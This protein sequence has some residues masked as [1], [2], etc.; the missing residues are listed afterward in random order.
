MAANKITLTKNDESVLFTFADSDHYLT[1]NGTIEVPL[2][3]LSLVIDESDMVTFRK[4]ASN[5]IFV[6]AP[7]SN[8]GMKKAELEEWYA[9]NMVDGGIN[10]EDVQELIDESID[11][12]IVSV[13]YDSKNHVLIF[14][15][16]NGNDITIDATDFIKDGMVSNV[17]VVGTNLVI[18]FNTD[19][20]KNPIS[21]PL[22]SF[23]DGSQY[24]DKTEIDTKLAT[25]AD[26]SAVTAAIDAV[27]TSLSGKADVS[28]VT[29]IAD[30]LSGKQDT[31]VSGT[32]IKTVNNETLLG[33]GNL[34]LATTSAV[35]QAQYDA[36]EQG[37]TL[38]P[39]MLYIITDASAI[40]IDNY[41]TS[42]Q[43]VSAIT[44]AV[45]GKADSTLVNAIAGQV[46]TKVNLSTYNTYTAATATALSGKVDN[47]DAVIDITTA[48]SANGTV[49]QYT[50][51]GTNRSD[52][53]LIG[54]INGEKIAKLKD[55]Q[56][57]ETSAFTAYSA[58]T[59]TSLSGKANISDLEDTELTL[60]QAINVVD[61]KVATKADT[62]AVTAIS[63]SLSGKQDTLIA[64]SGITIS[65]NVISADG[66]GSVIV[67]PTF[68]VSST[69]PVANSAITRNLTNGDG[70]VSYGGGKYQWE[71][72]SVGGYG[73]NK[74]FYLDTINGEPV[75]RKYSNTRS[76]QL[77]ETSAITTSMTSG[78]TDSQVPSAKAVY[79][80]L[81]AK[82]D[83]LVSGTNIK[84]INN[85]ARTDKHVTL[86]YYKNCLSR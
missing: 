13:S 66:G 50:K 60:A 54:S 1:G 83:A 55:F 80:T 38:D 73:T 35:T 16:R 86:L 23:F 2:N 24:Y 59:E 62:S 21:I 63:D 18:T 4:A 72:Y 65:G 64:G 3:S 25:K 26:V 51:D 40:D 8:F 53:L 37:G 43:T 76:L 68:D 47:G 45:S 7:I 57:L 82:Q 84:T 12:T 29:T 58:A 79:D 11:K 22:T 30:S 49:L 5:D 34:N 28:A 48:N 75:I 71:F 41:M 74:G 33:S 17:E 69:N 19:A 70:D 27:N 36:A 61:G 44:E 77:V 52:A 32:N 39:D 6:S 15:Q 56:L 31:L 85:I 20:G 78:S 81:G 10:E 14:N 42:A 67:D 46:A 9:E